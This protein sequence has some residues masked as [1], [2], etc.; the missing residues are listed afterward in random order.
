M[1]ATSLQSVHWQQIALT[2]SVHPAAYGRR[3]SQ[4]RSIQAWS[5][6]ETR[7]SWLSAHTQGSGCLARKD[8]LCT[9][10]MRK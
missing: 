4:T 3:N 5:R 1:T 6:Y 7:S 9:T 10:F 2:R 8:F